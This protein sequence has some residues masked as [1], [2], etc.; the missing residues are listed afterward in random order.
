MKDIP[1]GSA[2]RAAFEMQF[3]SAFLQ[4][5]AADIPSLSYAD[6]TIL[7]VHPEES[8]YLVQTTTRILSR[9][10]IVDYEIKAPIVDGEEMDPRDLAADINWVFTAAS[11][12]PD[13]ELSHKV[14]PLVHVELAKPVGLQDEAPSGSD[15]AHADPIASGLED[16]P[17]VDDE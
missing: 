7:N 3:K 6:I 1:E 11:H 4:T 10:I 16:G 12:D 8:P 17:H 14:A 13:C 2:A 15:A 5:I 9:T